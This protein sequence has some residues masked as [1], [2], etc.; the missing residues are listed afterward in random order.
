M[1][2]SQNGTAGSL[3]E[4]EVAEHWV[5]GPGLVLVL[6]GELD[7]SSSVDLRKRIDRAIRAGVTAMVIDLQDVTFI[8]SV[9]LAVLVAAKRKLGPTG[10]L[11]LVVGGSYVELV[12][13]ATALDD[14]LDVFEDRRAAE[15][16]AFGRRG[17]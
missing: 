17:G 6:A 15:A 12:L 16:F 9:S 3:W 1:R 13:Q 14:V 8:D 10:R 4:L 5:K 2:F 7:V 11:A